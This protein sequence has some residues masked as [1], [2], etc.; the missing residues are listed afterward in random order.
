M[1]I[2]H[3]V[4]YMAMGCGADGVCGGNGS[5]PPRMLGLR[6]TLARSLVADLVL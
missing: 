2:L 6:R 4:R 1:L 5:S 3:V